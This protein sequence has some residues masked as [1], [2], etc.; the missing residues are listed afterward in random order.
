MKCPNTKCGHTRDKADYYCHNCGRKFKAKTNGWAMFFAVLFVVAS[1]FATMFY[2]K[3]E[4]VNKQLEE[5][6][7]QIREDRV[8]IR[9]LRNALNQ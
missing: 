5:A 9:A 3:F 1:V 4:E 7:T 6:N 8:Y 2:I